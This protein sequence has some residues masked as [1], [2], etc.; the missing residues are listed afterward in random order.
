MKVNG[1]CLAEAI[2]SRF[3]NSHLW[4]IISFIPGESGS[5]EHAMFK[6]SSWRQLFRPVF[7]LCVAVRVAIWEHAGEHQRWRKPFQHG[8]SSTSWSN[9]QVSKVHSCSHDR[10]QTK[11]KDACFASVSFWWTQEDKAELHPGSIRTCCTS[12][13]LLCVTGSEIWESFYT[14]STYPLWKGQG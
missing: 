1:G 7:R 12:V 14:Q 10:C 5:M 11:E 9:F 6:V 4:K 2:Y 8:L 3:F 13:G